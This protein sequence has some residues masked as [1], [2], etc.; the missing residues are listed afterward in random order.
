VDKISVIIP[1]HNNAG[2]LRRVY[3]DVLREV[4]KL[5]VSYELLFIDNASR[6]GSSAILRLLSQQDYACHYVSLNHRVTPVSAIFLGAQLSNGDFL[7]LTDTRHPAYLIPEL[8]RTLCGR[9]QCCGGDLITGNRHMRKQPFFKL[10][11]R[12]YVGEALQTED[13]SAFRKILLQDDTGTVWLPYTELERSLITWQDRLYS[14][15][16]TYGNRVLTY[17]GMGVFILLT[18]VPCFLL[19]MMFLDLLYAVLLYTGLFI[20]LLFL[21][22]RFRHHPY[23]FRHEQ[24]LLTDIRESTLPNPPI[25]KPDISKL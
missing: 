2:A 1:C 17:I 5:P 3:T 21:F 12:E 19:F 20:S 4:K 8:Y 11:R 6:D 13:I 22:T 16:I 25:Q 23:F 14:L 24:L 10:L 7:M 9:T 15:M 18:G